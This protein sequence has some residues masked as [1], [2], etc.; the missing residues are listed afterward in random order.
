M[1]G[2]V[3][4]LKSP[5][6]TQR[7]F[8]MTTIWIVDETC[9]EHGCLTCLLISKDEREIPDPVQVGDIIRFHRLRTLRYQGYPQAKISPG[10]SWLII[11][12]NK[13]IHSHDEYTFTPKDR[14]RINEI[15]EWIKSSPNLHTEEALSY[16]KIS[17]IKAEDKWFNL[18]LQVISIHLSTSD[19]SCAIIVGW[20]STVPMF[21][22][23]CY[24][25]MGDAEDEVDEELLRVSAGR[26]IKIHC[27][28]DHVAEA[29][30]LVSGQFIQVVNAHAKV[31]N[32]HTITSAAVSG[33]IDHE[34]KA[35]QLAVLRK[36]ACQFCIL[37]SGVCGGVARRS[38]ETFDENKE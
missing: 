20:D 5:S 13:R 28:D 17:T 10:F 23:F 32:D 27:F 16:T 21:E 18:T 14:E 22:S 6:I 7:G 31:I 24:C 30:R 25:M 11:R 8:H 1:Y 35:E 3:K 38:S 26:A 34:K 33:F 9:E 37:N 15:Q 2:V 4:S 12:G 36:S 29:M 19:S